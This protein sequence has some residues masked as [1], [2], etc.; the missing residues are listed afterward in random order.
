MDMAKNWHVLSVEETLKEL[1]S[2]NEGLSD[3]EASTRL[4]KFGPNELE[5]KKK[6]S[7]IVIFFNQFKDL[8]ILI[9][10]AAGLV[11]GLLGD[12]KDAI[13]ISVIVLI[14]AVV[15]FIQEYRAEK[16]MEALKK[17]TSARAKV[18]RNHATAEI[19]AKELVPGDVVMLEAGDMVPA[20]LRLI[21]T[22]ALKIEEA[23]LTGESYPVE[24][25]IDAIKEEKVQIGDRFNMAY[26]STLVTYGRAT[27]IVTSTGMQTEIGS[28][29]KML[30]GEE[31][32]TPLQKRLGEFSK[33]LS[34]IVL[35][36]CGVLFISGLIRGEETIN[37]LMVAISL[38][39]A[40]IPEALP[41]V[42]T[43]SLAL[44]ARKL[45]RINSL[46]RKLPAVETL[47]SVTFIC[48]D[49]T[50]TL[51]QNKMTVEDLWHNENAVVP[52]F[53]PHQLLI[54]CMAA[55]QDTKKDKEGN[56]SGDP[57]E[58][59]MIEYAMKSDFFEK[60]WSNKY[61]RVEELPF[62]SDRKMM[63]TVHQYNSRWLV[64]TKG[65]LEAILPRCVEV[66][67]EKISQMSSKMAEGGMR[68]LGYGCKYI[69]TEPSASNMEQLE[70]DLHFVG[71]V[72]LLD[73]PR[74][75][76]AQSVDECVNAGIIPVMITGDHPATAKAIGGMIGIL[77][78]E[79][80]RVITGGELAEMQPEE[81]QNNIEKIKVYARVNPEQKLNIVQTLQKKG[82]YVSMTGDGVNDAPALRQANI[83]VA[84]GITGT[85][86]SKEAAHMILLDDNFATIVKAVKEGRRIFDNIRKFVRYIMTGNSSEIWTIMLAPLIG[87]PIPLL[88]IHILWIN[89]VTD[90]LPALALANEDAEKNVMH[91]P[92]RD[93]KE[94]IFA[95]GLGI[96]VLWVGLLMGG[97]CLGIQAWAIANG[98]DKWQTLVFC[99]LCF[100]QMAHVM[101]IRSETYFLFR[102]GIFSNLFLVGSVLLTFGLQLCLV[103]LPVF[104]DIFSTQPL[105]LN[106]MLI[107][108]GAALV[109]FHAVELEKFIRL[110]RLK[111]KGMI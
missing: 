24:K 90:G 98:N 81:F 18:R 93:P 25:N 6:K 87:L 35:G 27:G 110:K 71:F 15:G 48:T 67:E 32:M 55:N 44:G 76:A 31:A 106:E 51:T 29:A 41:A 77:R 75:E 37:M 103:Y 66:N 85:D 26:K 3:E 57:T 14:N 43:I 1:S 82:H 49:K 46:I 8:M 54:F 38:A 78:N 96:H 65:A 107:C 105:T 59:A 68:V 62:D 10:L 84:M 91:R 9:L 69:D 99:T 2:S 92:P 22:H 45:V 21:E 73:P 70:S 74:E 34:F 58:V 60:D 61:K 89:L 11:S 30:Q 108:L 102:Q 39:V 111:R 104:N 52:D 56:I 13:V 36:I 86:V 5:E 40:A 80:D 42:V 94:S 88:P 47:G 17:M 50:G 19:S 72:G 33:K 4:Q 79:N 53:N 83:G 97:L 95:K 109:I 63:S 100:G 7:K 101:A 23:S 20:D 64:I 12:I 28:I 16:A